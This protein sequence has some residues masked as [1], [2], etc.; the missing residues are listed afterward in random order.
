MENL[1]TSKWKESFKKTNSP[2]IIDV[3]T[4]LEWVNGTIDGAIKIDFN[5]QQDFINFIEKLE[6]SNNYYVYCKSG[7]RSWYACQM[8]EQLGLSTYNLKN[9]ITQW[10]EPLTKS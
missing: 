7:V 6:K 9:G 8:M 10:D 5:Q 1:S 3:R 4:P 2:L